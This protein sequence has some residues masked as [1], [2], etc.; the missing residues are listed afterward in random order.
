M[1]RELHEANYFAYGYRKTW[2][3]LKR[4][5]ETV[6]RDRVKR[7]MRAHEITGRQAPRQAVAHHD[8]RSGRPPGPGSRQP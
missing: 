4:A 3:A 1:I 2:L 5:G 7:L 8:H 6:G